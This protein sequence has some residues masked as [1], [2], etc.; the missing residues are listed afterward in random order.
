MKDPADVIEIKDVFLKFLTSEDV[1]A[2][3]I[4][5]IVFRE[6]PRHCP[7]HNGVNGENVPHVFVED[8]VF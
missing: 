7:D 5:S 4:C 6:C 1:I 3:R 2:S 8:K